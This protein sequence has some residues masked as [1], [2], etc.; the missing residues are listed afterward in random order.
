V[1]SGLNHKIAHFEIARHFRGEFLGVF[2][3][4]RLRMDVVE[5]CR[6]AL[7]IHHGQHARGVADAYP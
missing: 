4:A 7:P 1:A 6:F 5:C 3:N 2:G